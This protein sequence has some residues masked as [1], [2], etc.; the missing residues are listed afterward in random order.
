LR[1]SASSDPSTG[2]RPAGVALSIAGFD[3]SSGAG[4]T[5]DLAVFAAHGIFGTSAISAMTVQSTMGV[6]AVRAVDAAW[7]LRT[8]E[9]IS[10][11]LPPAGV[12]IGMLASDAIVRTVA[13]FLQTV[14]SQ[15]PVVI[16]PVLRSSSGHQLLESQ[17]ERR[18][19]SELLPVAGWLTPNWAELS[20]LTGRPVR[21]VEQA[22]EA[23]DV[24]GKQ[25]PRLYIVATGG[26]QNPPVDLLRAPGGAVQTFTGEYVDTTS[27]HGTGCAFSS[28]L[29]SRLILGD[30]PAVA[31]ARAK[32]YVTEALRS[33]PG[34]GHGR[35]P[36]DLLW[37]LRAGGATARR[38]NC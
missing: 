30:A 29:L 20:T 21:T 16:D 12:K 4:V 2:Y 11:D 13:E 1:S 28:A 38:R 24:L 9:H 7:L 15:V 26:D 23:A 25:H 22:R 31:V 37:P 36:L 14:P 19:H 8:L 10:V 3:P 18:I 17:G 5:A 35:G 6:A 34:L 27:T 33:A 32:A